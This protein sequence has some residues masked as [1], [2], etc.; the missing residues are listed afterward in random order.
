[1]LAI[2]KTLLYLWN[3]T[4]SFRKQRAD[5]EG[6]DKKLWL[7]IIIYLK[8]ITDVSNYKIVQ[9]CTQLDKSL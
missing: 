4:A 1:M 7:L 5:K 6:L 2:Y 3:H 8:T 9:D